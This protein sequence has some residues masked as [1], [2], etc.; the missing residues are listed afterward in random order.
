MRRIRIR[1]GTVHGDLG[2]GDSVSLDGAC[3]TA[4]ELHED[5]FS[6]DSIGTTMSRTISGRYAVDTPVNLERAARLGS[7]LDGHLVQGHVD[8]LGEL[9]SVSEDG[10][11]RRM[12][13][14]LPEFVWKQ[15]ILHGS[16]TFNGVSLTVNALHDAPG[17]RVAIIPHTARETHLTRRR[18]GDAVNLEADILAKH[19]AR[20]LEAW[21]DAPR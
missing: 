4:V 12:D 18:P 14:A 11:Y 5:G 3:H 21:K 13:F 8:G 10:G 19:V 6:V 2:L 7:R 16:I 1:S 9:R 20:L 17:C 15:T